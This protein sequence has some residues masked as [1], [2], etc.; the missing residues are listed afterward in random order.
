MRRV[1]HRICC[2]GES[3]VDASDVWWSE[4]REVAR[5]VAIRRWKR[6]FK[7]AVPIALAAAAGTF[8]ACD[9]RAKPPHTPAPDP[10]TPQ[11]SNLP[12]ARDAASMPRPMPQRMR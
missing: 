12:A 4:N 6:R 3:F 11:I 9:S 1:P 2:R 7:A 5:R 8:I 10:T